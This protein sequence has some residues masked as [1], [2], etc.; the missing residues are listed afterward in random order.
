MEDL[1]RKFINS[2]LHIETVADFPTV[3][4]L[5]RGR[6]REYSESIRSGF[7]ELLWCKNIGVA[8][9]YRMTYVE[10]GEEE[11]LYR[12]LGELYEYLYEGRVEPPRLPDDC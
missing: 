12:F 6:S 3:K 11:S 9:W 7:Q 5:S 1:F 10:F 2:A 4:E 8:E